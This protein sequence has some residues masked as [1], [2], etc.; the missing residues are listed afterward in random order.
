MPALLVGVPDHTPY[1][2]A[3]HALAA[4]LLGDGETAVNDADAVARQHGASYLDRILAE[5]AAGVAL[6]RC[7]DNE[8]ALRRLER[9]RE[10]ALTVGDSVAHSL[11]ANV[12][13]TTTG[14]SIHPSEVD[15]APGWRTVVGALA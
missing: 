3:V 11:V 12:E 9:A 13:A 2:S 4:V 1:Y 7:G 15:L 8:G 14:P 10:I 6:T 5:L